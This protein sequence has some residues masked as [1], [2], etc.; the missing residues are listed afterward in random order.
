[1]V[2]A[3]RRCAWLCYKILLDIDYE[4]VIQLSWHYHGCAL[5]FTLPVTLSH[6]VYIPPL[7]KETKPSGL[8]PCSQR[9]YWH[10]NPLPVA[11][12]FLEH[13]YASTIRYQQTFNYFF[14]VCNSCTMW[15][16]TAEHSRAA[17]ASFLLLLLQ[18]GREK[19]NC[20]NSAF[21]LRG[22]MRLSWS[23]RYRINII[24]LL[25]LFIIICL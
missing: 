5:N 25:H 2:W 18:N 23:A 15:P 17:L 9:K 1:M 13:H 6:N 8:T 11:Y 16:T 3:D 4:Y 24:C 10:N 7:T 12:W 22:E 20:S 21:K 14:F 19:Y